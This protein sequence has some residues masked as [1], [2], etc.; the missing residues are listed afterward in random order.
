M[1]GGSYSFMARSVRT[2]SLYSKS[3]ASEIFSSQLN[4]AMSPLNLGIRESRDSEE[5]PNSVPVIIG[6]DVTGSMG[7]IPTFLIKEGLPNIMKKI[8][9]S[10]VADPQI[11][12]TAIGDQFSDQAPCQVG[13]YESS[14]SL[15]DYWLEKI[16]IEGNGGGDREESYLLAW[17]IA[18][19]HTA[20]DSFEKRR[21]KG[22]LFTIG[23]EATHKKLSKSKI[24]S[25]FGC[26]KQ[27]YTHFE[28]LEE[29][30]KRYEIFHIHI[31]EGSNGT[32][33]SIIDGWKEIL[34]DNCII[35][36]K[37]TDIV[38]IIAS[39]IVANPTTHEAFN[40]RR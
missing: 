18:A 5:H 36:N 38:N 16:W 27:E 22:Y 28:L 1:G 29:A 39:K 6:L 35:A 14:D 40:L 8:I 7:R 20:I 24:K 10:G 13:Q 11:L 2:G 26:D 15:I 32:N 12:F 37:S 23:D 21:K 30:K 31:K 17:Y 3:S 19:Y 9:D 25:I 33:Q 4:S 34:G